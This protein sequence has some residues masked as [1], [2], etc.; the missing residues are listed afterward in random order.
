LLYFEHS[1]TGSQREKKNKTKAS[2][3]IHP[4]RQRIIAYPSRR[5]AFA[6]AKIEPECPSERDGAHANRYYPRAC[7]NPSHANSVLANAILCTAAYTF[8]ITAECKR[9][10]HVTHARVGVLDL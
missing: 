9:C 4:L 8:S 5:T 10:E 6:I 2:H 7:E 1:F 3:H